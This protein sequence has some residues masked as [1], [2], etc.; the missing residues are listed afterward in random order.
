VSLLRVSP[1]LVRLWI[2][3][4]D[5]RIL[6]PVSERILTQAPQTAPINQSI[7]S[8]IDSQSQAT[9]INQTQAAPYVTSQSQQPVSKPLDESLSED[10]EISKSYE[11]SVADSNPA[12]DNRSSVSATSS[13]TMGT[14]VKP[15][16]NK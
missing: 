3:R 2:C 16:L 14:Q 12:Q 5:P 10:E 4:P 11:D 15:T 9:P 8:Q 1:S 7:P 13:A 6:S